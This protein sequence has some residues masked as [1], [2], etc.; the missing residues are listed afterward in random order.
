M[1]H[2]PRGLHAATSSGSPQRST[3]VTRL[4]MQACIKRVDIDSGS[5]PLIFK[6]LGK[7]SLSKDGFEGMMGELFKRF[8]SRTPKSEELKALDGLFK[9][10]KDPTELAKL[11]CFIVGTSTEFLYY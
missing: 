7:A 3:D 8:Y 4:V 11:A 10:S 5:S 1:S 9:L 6:D 2:D